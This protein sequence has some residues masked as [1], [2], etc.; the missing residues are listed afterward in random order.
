MSQPEH[1]E[2]LIIGSGEGGNTWRGTWPN[3]GTARPSL[4]AS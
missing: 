4:N 3:Q 1:F 2:M